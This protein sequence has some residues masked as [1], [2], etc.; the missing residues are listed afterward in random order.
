MTRAGRLWSFAVMTRAKFATGEFRV[1]AK[2][3]CRCASQGPPD[4]TPAARNPPFCHAFDKPRSKPI[5]LAGHDV[6]A[7]EP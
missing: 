4:H 6:S 1:I 7:R 5:C 3:A 2:L